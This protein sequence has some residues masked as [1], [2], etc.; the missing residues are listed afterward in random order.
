M[1]TL[2]WINWSA[3]PQ[4]LL[5]GYDFLQCLVKWF[6]N[7]HRYSL[8]WKVFS[9]L[10]SC[11]FTLCYFQGM[12]SRIWSFF[13]RLTSLV[14]Y[15][16]TWANRIQFTTVSRDVFIILICLHLIEMS[17]C[18]IQSVDTPCCLHV[19]D[20]PV[21][22]CNPIQELCCPA[23]QKWWWFCLSAIINSFNLCKYDAHQQITFFYSLIVSSFA[24]YYF[25][26]V[27]PVC[28]AGSLSQISP[29]WIWNRTSGWF[30]N[31]IID[32]TDEKLRTFFPVFRRAVT[33]WFILIYWG[34]L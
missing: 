32:M 14:F 23:V 20:S 10:F 7:Q 1:N 28:V 34:K 5:I 17:L 4:S 8:Y 19:L 2:P 11:L 24:V 29:S 26:N 12:C 31:I 3:C 15:G 13:C 16:S 27:S 30:H 18:S 25:H 22:Q 6:F 33:F 9:P 21:L